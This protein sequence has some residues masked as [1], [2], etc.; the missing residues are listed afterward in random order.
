MTVP[1]F[2][3]VRSEHVGGPLFSPLSRPPPHL[4]LSG[5]NES[6]LQLSR[7]RTPRLIRSHSD[8]LAQCHG[9][10]A[11]LEQSTCSRSDANCCE[12]RRDKMAWPT[13]HSRSFMCVILIVRASLHP[14]LPVRSDRG[15]TS[16]GTKRTSYLDRNRD[17][18]PQHCH[19]LG[20][21]HKRGIYR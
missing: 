7:S 19:P 18:D 17:G 21:L 16:T 11:S 15:L 4:P 2:G 10:A 5:Q 14:L 13:Q 3:R 1:T 9:N 12:A 20:Q 6:L 8:K